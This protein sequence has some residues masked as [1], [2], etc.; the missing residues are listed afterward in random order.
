MQ[1]SL[2][3]LGMNEPPPQDDAMTV[4]PLAGDASALS[5]LTSP[6]EPPRQPSVPREPSPA[7]PAGAAANADDGP[8]S[9]E[10]E[11]E[12]RK[13]LSTPILCVHNMADFVVLA[14]LRKRKRVTRQSARKASD[15][16][17]ESEDDLPLAASA[18]DAPARR[19]RR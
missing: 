3:T 5:P 4:D 19:R 17:G 12:Q 14:I 13:Y 9:A 6:V 1:K 16:F 18:A 11:D 8:A 7:P 10:E 15:V 2:S